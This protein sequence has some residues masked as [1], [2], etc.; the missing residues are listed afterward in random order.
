MAQE[1]HVYLVVIRLLPCNQDRIAESM[2]T[3]RDILGMLSGGNCE[4]A[5]NSAVVDVAG[6][7]IQTRR[8]A[9]Q[10]EGKLRSPNSP[11]FHFGGETFID[12]PLTNQDE[13][14]V[15]EIGSDFRAGKGFT[16]MG[17]WLKNRYLG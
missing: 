2:P 17:A 8:T 14:L 1:E 6:F 15:L 7:L 16:R 12:P 5:F 11:D 13:I 9:A 4:P 10:I 3:I